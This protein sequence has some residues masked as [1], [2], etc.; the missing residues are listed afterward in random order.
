M[1]HDNSTS[2]HFNQLGSEDLAA[3]EWAAR[4]TTA[5]MQAEALPRSN[6]NGISR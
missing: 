5:S 3:L 4:V 1:T 6:Q 2:Q